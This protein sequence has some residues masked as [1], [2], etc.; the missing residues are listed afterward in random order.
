MALNHFNISVHIKNHLRIA[1]AC[2]FHPLESHLAV[3]ALGLHTERLAPSSCGID[4]SLLRFWHTFYSSNFKGSCG[5][6]TSRCASCFKL[7]SSASVNRRRP[8]RSL[9]CVS[10][11]RPCFSQ[12]KYVALLTG[13]AANASPILYNFLPSITNGIVPS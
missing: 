11:T 3:P 12:R 13:A 4:L 6:S 2:G 7:S 5:D 1:L 8:F 10:G 9:Y